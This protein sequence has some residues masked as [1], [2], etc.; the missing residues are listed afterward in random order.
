[1][2][3][4]FVDVG[5][6]RLYYYAAGTRGAGDPV[7]F[8]HGFPTS[9]HLWGEVVALMPAGHRIVV[10]DLLGYG[11]SDP[12]GTRSLSLY[13]HAERVIGLMD[14]LRITR[15]C[16]VGHD[17]GGGIAQCLAIHWP[18]RV[19]HLALIDSV[20]FSQWPTRDVR[21]ARRLLP[22]VRHLPTNWLLPIV[23]AD[24][25]RGYY[26]ALRATHSIDRYQR[27]FNS[28][29]GRRVFLQHVASLDANETMKLAERLGTI[30]APTAVIWGEHDP[31]L[32]IALGARLA[33]AIPGATFDIA[34]DSRHFTPEDC[35]RVLADV[36]AN[37]LSR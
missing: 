9:G 20:A 11:R 24:L 32:S 1:M 13:A 36:L 28:D 15:A 2:R 3:G 19:S 7:V 33:A 21:V 5:G 17:I 34:P 4:E 35:P 18:D 10:A 23:R 8:L 27:P 16:I 6:A 25:E 30:S 14:A 26:D 22:I 37:L 31:F 29:E 12:P